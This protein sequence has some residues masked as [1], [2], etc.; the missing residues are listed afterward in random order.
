MAIEPDTKDWT[1]VL[2]QRCPE[3][4]FDASSVSFAD[5]AALTRANATRWAEV[6]Q[7][8][9][10]AVRPAADTW[11]PLEYACH[12]RDVFRLYDMRLGLMLADDGPTFANWDQDEAAVAAR[13]GDQ[14]PAI[15]GAELAAAAR[16][17]SESFE[18]VTIDQLGRTG[19]RSD[20]AQ[21]TVDS[22]AR[23]FVH[24]PIHH[25]WDVTR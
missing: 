5:V 10:A 9:D 25:I 2:E 24:D 22:F 7:R 23:Y 6:L 3:C 20:G 13:Y 14:D 15:V 12:V 17:I 1:W 19:T 11:S 21:F 18:A 8:P 16:S 4:G